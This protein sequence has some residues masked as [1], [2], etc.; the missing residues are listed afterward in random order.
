MASAEEHRAAIRAGRDALQQAIAAA[1]PHWELSPGGDGEASWAPRKVAEHIVASDRYFTAMI[2]TVM[3]GKP[4]ARLEYAF[5][6]PGEAIAALDASTVDCEKVLRYI[7]DRDLDKA[8]PLP[9][10]IPAPKT[11]EGTLLLLAH[12]LQ[13]H[14]RQIGGA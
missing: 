10:R 2:A 1:G 4:P 5:A 11:I 14:A 7:E 6:D 12:H 13:D 9:E 8:V 3:E